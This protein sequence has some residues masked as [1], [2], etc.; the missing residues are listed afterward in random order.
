MYTHQNSKWQTE[1]S[2][3]IYFER[4][5][6]EKSRH[7]YHSSENYL[8]VKRNIYTS[9]T[10]A[11]NPQNLFRTFILPLSSLIYM[12]FVMKIKYLI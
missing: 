10:S 11:L 4:I 5:T 1:I 6:E 2:V 7:Y 9:G 8:I 12:V 3:T